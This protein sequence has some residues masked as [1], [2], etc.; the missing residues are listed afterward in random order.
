MVEF[1]GR[2]LGLIPSPAISQFDG[3]II[4]WAIHQNSFGESIIEKFVRLLD[5]SKS[6]LISELTKILSTNKMA[7][8]KMVA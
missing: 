1:G 8:I 7:P 5:Q 6:S 2:N 4:R 3:R